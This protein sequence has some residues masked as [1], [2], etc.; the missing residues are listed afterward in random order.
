MS[1]TLK[2]TDIMATGLMTFAL[3]L[4]AG[5]II[6]PPFL[7]YMAGTELVSAIMGFLLT[8]VGLPLLG[9]LACARVGGGLEKLT[10]VFPEKMA[11][12]FAVVLFLAIGPLFAAPRTAVVSYE[13]GL[14]P[15]I[16]ESSGLSLALFSLGFFA[17]ALYLALFP[18]RLL[19]TVGKLITPMLVAVLALIAIGAFMFP[20]GEAG[21]ATESM[22]QQGFFNGFRE[23]Y[24]TMDTLGALVF[25]VVIINAIHSKGVTES[26]QV[27]RYTFI[28]GLIAAV[29]L[30]LVYLVLGYI[31]ST[32][33]SLIAQPQNGAEIISLFVNAVFGVWGKA[34]LAITVILACLTTAVGLLSACGEYFSRVMPALSYR[35][36]VVVCALASA[37]IANVGLNTLLTVTIPALLIIYP[38]AIALILV[39]LLKPLLT[40]PG[41]VMLFVLAPV[42]L[43]S[44]I[45][46]LH[47]AGVAFVNPAY[48]LL[49]YLPLQAEG[50]V[51]LMPG[52]LGGVLGVLA[53][54]NTAIT[55]E[56]V[57]G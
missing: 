29:G 33:H 2:T 14:L 31:G 17:V 26:K 36:W 57:Q 21:I 52:V 47:A 15:F 50:L 23:G 54:R 9:V 27:A 13:L 42:G 10:A 5:N 38:I 49:A 22:I 39:T 8:G 19:E 40:M 46:G 1:Q 48:Q 30:S 37:L 44:L 16:G 12:I 3:F 6:F 11:L 51:W 20:Q 4:G 7:G 25:G 24:Q 55:A 41:R 28:A 56:P 32:S 18:G 53:S 35:G 45:E 34:V 43:I